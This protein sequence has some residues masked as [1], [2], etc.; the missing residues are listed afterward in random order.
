MKTT[1]LFLMIAL[2]G[3]GVLYCRVNLGMSFDAQAATLESII[4]R[5]FVICVVVWA[6]AAALAYMNS[7]DR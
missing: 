3:A 1:I 7:R 4:P 2:G 5:L 6:A